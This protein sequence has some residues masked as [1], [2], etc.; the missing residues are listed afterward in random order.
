MEVD[1]ISEDKTVIVKSKDGKEFHA[2]F[3]QLKMSGKN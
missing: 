3:S 1:N 2:K